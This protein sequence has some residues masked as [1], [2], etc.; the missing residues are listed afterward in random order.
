MKL[1]ETFLRRMKVTND[2]SPI[3]QDNK[4]QPIDKFLSL[5]VF[6]VYFLTSKQSFG[7]QMAAINH[8]IIINTT[9]GITS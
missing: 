5:V 9:F 8:D 6:I 7:V 3:S 2:G 1:V 4:S